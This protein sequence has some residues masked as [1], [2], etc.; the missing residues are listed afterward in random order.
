MDKW[1]YQIR[2]TVADQLSNNLRNSRTCST[3]HQI[4]E[5]AIINDMQ[6]VCT[7]D[8]FKNYCDEAENSKIEFYPLYQWTK[9]TIEDPVKKQKHLNSFA[10]YQGKNQVY[11]K[12]LACKIRDALLSIKDI[13]QLKEVRM[14][15]SNPANNPQP[16]DM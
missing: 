13:G 11:S 16:P 9:K 12:S 1:F 5:I 4:L 10:F 15:D 7:F 14:I 6:L 2:I 8:A 3:S